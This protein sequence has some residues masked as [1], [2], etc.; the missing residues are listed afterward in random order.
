MLQANCLKQLIFVQKAN[1]LKRP[2]TQ[3]N[4]NKDKRLQPIKADYWSAD[5]TKNGYPKTLT[6]SHPGENVTKRQQKSQDN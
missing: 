6:S 3:G 4:Q 1:L 5:L 2:Q